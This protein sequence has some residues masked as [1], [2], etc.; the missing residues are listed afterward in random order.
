[1]KN[2]FSEFKN[3]S[4]NEWSEKIIQ[5]LKGKPE[6]LLT[7]T[8]E[9]EEISYSSFYH[10]EDSI[11]RNK[12]GNLPYIR[13]IKKSSNEWRNC[14]YELINKEKK[15][16]ARCLKALMSG[17]DMLW[18]Q[19]NRKDVDWNTVLEDI[20]TEYISVV[21]E[22]DD[23]ENIKIL[24]KSGKKNITYAFDAYK[25]GFDALM[26][27]YSAFKDYQFPFL[28]VDASK[29]QQA[30]G[31]ISQQIGF[32]LNVGH[33]YLLHLVNKGFSVDEASACIQF[34]FGVGNDYLKESLKF[35][36][37]RGL[38]SNVIAAYIPEH[39]C[40]HH[41]IIHAFITHLNKSL[42]D[43]Y[44]NL[45]RQT[46]EVM[47][48]VN[49]NIDS[50]CVLPYN[51]YSYEG[52]SELAERMALNITNILKEESYFDKVCDPLGGSYSL[53]N[54]QEKISDRA[55][56]NF[57]EIEANGGLMQTSARE[58][59]YN[60]INTVRSKRVTNFSNGKQTLIGVNKFENRDEIN[61]SWI[62][63]PNYDGL[64]SLILENEL[65]NSNK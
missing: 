29:I 11:E 46:T 33:E 3:I 30:G 17:S 55:W 20:Q 19:V 62:D 36:T 41:T 28:L 63:I 45:L 40:S 56:G 39:K 61:N 57:Q 21:L 58:N 64:L 47:S 18:F 26:E 12:P 65:Q 42:K 27:L 9:I 23:V 52:S 22:T 8:D 16:N 50:I 37:F 38:W 14:H 51:H 25:N 54:L 10:K 53:E 2:L 13:G 44:T 6:E 4:K 5:D 35:R 24:T 31:N 32:A 49:G 60:Q 15:N 59:F 7:I 34:K 1:M 48:A 43:P